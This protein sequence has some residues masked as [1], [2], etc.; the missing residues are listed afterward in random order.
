[1]PRLQLAAYRKPTDDFDIS[2]SGHSPF[3]DVKWRDF[4]PRNGSSDMLAMPLSYDKI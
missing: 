2:V 3:V 4:G 1:M